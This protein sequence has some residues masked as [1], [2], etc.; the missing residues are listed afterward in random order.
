MMLDSSAGGAHL[1]AL[2][3]YF[4]SFVCYSFEIPSNISS[5]SAHSL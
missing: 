5:V 4:L 2:E 1:V 3:G